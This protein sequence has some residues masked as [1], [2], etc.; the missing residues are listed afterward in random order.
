MEILLKLLS[1]TI[2]SNKSFEF[3]TMRK[4]IF[5]C[6]LTLFVLNSQ[7][8][9]A[10][11][12]IS[13]AT[14]VVSGGEVGYLYNA[15]GSMSD[16]DV[17]SWK[18]TGGTVVGSENSATNGS[19]IASG[20]TIRI[21]WNKGVS[22]GTIKLT[23]SRLGDSELSVK[24]VDFPNSISLPNGLINVGTTI[25][26]TGSGPSSSICT[27]LSSFWWEVADAI[28]GPFESIDGATDKNLTVVVNQGKKFYRRVLSVN[29]NL[30]FSN[31][32]SIDPQ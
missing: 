27:P 6:L 5:C 23:N 17:F 2:K 11:V 30:L 19:V 31:I 21:I 7:N 25:T 32:I 28:S 29:G 13:G 12:S 8:T 14:C 24:I 3:L 10:Q 22:N 18:V 16:Q 1:T 4:S 9:I 26:I 15:T 20:S